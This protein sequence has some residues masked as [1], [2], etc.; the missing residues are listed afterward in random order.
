LLVCG[1]AREAEQG[2]RLVTRAFSRQEVAVV[3][4]AM[5]VNQLHPPPGEAF[6]GIDLR[7]I[8]D[9]LHHAG[10]HCGRL[11]HAEALT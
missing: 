7:R 2:Q 6:E 8:D 10:N 1:Q 11:A 4:A 5:A 9:I 3:A